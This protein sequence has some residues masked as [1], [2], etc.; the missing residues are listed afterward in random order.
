MNFCLPLL[1]QYWCDFFCDFQTPWIRS[2]LGLQ[3]SVLF[4]ENKCVVDP[5]TLILCTP[6][7]PRLWKM[8]LERYHLWL[9]WPTEEMITWVE[10]VY[11]NMQSFR[12]NNVIWLIFMVVDCCTCAA[13]LILEFIRKI[14]W[15]ETQTEKCD[16]HQ[17]YL[18][19]NSLN[20]DHFPVIWGSFCM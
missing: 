10:C 6:S 9:W 18:K 4:C 8:C 14:T 3:V 7:R 13:L 19:K 5:P 15:V 16:Y 11:M 1:S 2:K 12:V 17:L 20:T